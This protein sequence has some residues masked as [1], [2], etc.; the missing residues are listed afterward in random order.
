M[1]QRCSPA[2]PIANSNSRHDIQRQSSVPRVPHM[3][4]EHLRTPPSLIGPAPSRLQPETTEKQ[5]RSAEYTC[6]SPQEE[7]FHV[8]EW[9]QV[10]SSPCQVPLSS[11]SRPLKA[12]RWSP[13]APET[14]G[15]SSQG[16][17]VDTRHPRWSIVV[18]KLVDQAIE[19]SQHPL[20]GID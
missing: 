8:A 4:C 13:T 3:S 10:V 11:P 7:V 9:P 14:V 6:K 5:R 18:V 2:H 17:F 16:T 1:Q 12:L 19:G 20:R 15:R